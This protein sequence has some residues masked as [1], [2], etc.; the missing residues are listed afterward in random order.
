MVPFSPLLE[1]FKSDRLLDIA[2]SVPSWYHDFV[3]I[4][5]DRLTPNWTLEAQVDF[6]NSLSKPASAVGRDRVLMRL[7]TYLIAFYL[8]RRRARLFSLAMAPH[9][10]HWQGF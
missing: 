2:H 10:Q 9:L 1:D 4:T 6:M 7:K 3:P 5:G 8:Y